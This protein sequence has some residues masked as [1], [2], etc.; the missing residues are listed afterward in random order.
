M[1][2]AVAL[3]VG[4]GMVLG[5]DSASTIGADFMQH[6][7]YFN[8]EK[9]VNLYK[10]L[11]I[12]YVTFGLGSFKNRSTTSLAKDLREL[13]TRSG[14]PGWQL[15]PDTYTVEEAAQRVRKFFFEEHYA[16]SYPTKRKDKQ[17]NE[18]DH[19]DSMGFVVA[20]FS[21]G[22]EQAEAWSVMIDDSGVCAPPER[23]IGQD[24]PSM[25]WWAGMPEPLTRLMMGFSS[26]AVGALATLP[27]GIPEHVVIAFLRNVPTPRLFNTGMP[28]QDAI[29]L[30]K[31]MV[32]T[33]IGFVRFAPRPPMVHGPVDVAAI[34][35]HEGFRWVQRKHYF[36]TV[37]NPTLSI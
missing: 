4:D 26:E 14:Q 12:G 2:I 19:F 15:N 24:V 7:V 5:A 18:I 17:G 22:A 35:K 11:P 27:P 13:L 8:A 21:A 20:G 16:K 31:F 37:L 3:K 25:A 1:T 28:I 23:I 34:T 6:K 36:D 9:I 10:G 30:V 29:D 33:T 32:E